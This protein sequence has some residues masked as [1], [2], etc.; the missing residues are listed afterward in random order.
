VHISGFPLPP[1]VES[2]NLVP[3]SAQKSGSTGNGGNVANLLVIAIAHINIP[4]VAI[5]FFTVVFDPFPLTGPKS[6]AM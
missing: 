4:W 5:P 3:I 1:H 6:A 2:R